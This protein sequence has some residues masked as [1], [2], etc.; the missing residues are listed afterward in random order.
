M[1]AHHQYR[2]LARCFKNRLYQIIYVE[3]WYVSLVCFPQVAGC[4]HVLSS[5]NGW[6]KTCNRGLAII[7]LSVCTSLST[8]HLCPLILN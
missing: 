3:N 7:A 8:S 5:S 1:R 2:S 6:L 4:F